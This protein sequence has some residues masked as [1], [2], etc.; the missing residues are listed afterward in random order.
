MAIS[1]LFW[2]KSIFSPSPKS[3]P[4]DDLD[5]LQPRQYRLRQKVEIVDLPED[6]DMYRKGES[7]KC[8]YKI[9]L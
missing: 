9:D 7:Q 6:A 8:R 3:W 2:S 5:H 1:S 4:G